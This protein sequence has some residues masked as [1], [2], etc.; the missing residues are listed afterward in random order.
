MFIEMPRD[1][2]CLRT[3][4][5]PDGALNI[6]FGSHVG[7]VA[8]AVMRNRATP[9]NFESERLQVTSTDQPHHLQNS[10]PKLG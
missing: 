3:A 7:R 4:I 5:K 2:A 10:L 9:A 1:Y 6:Y 8:T